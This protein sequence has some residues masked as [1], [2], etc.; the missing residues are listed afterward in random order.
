VASA[1]RSTLAETLEEGLRAGALAS[2][3]TQAL[4]VLVVA[5]GVLAL[6]SLPG[7]ATGDAQGALAEF[8]RFPTLLGG[9]A[10]GSMLVTLLALLGGGIFAK[11]ADVAADV[12]GKIDAALPEDSSENPATVTDLVGDQVGDVAVRGA[13]A[14]A[15]TVLETLAAMMAAALVV[16]DNPSLPSAAA[17][18]LMPL[19]VRAFTLVTSSFGVLVVRTNDSE[20]PASALGRGLFVATLLQVVVAMGAAKWLL[21]AYFWRCGLAAAAGGIA[22]FAFWHV[23][24]YYGQER[25]RPV[26]T[27][28]E[29]ARAGATTVTLRGLLLAAEATLILVL[30]VVVALYSGYWLGQG[31]GLV[32]GGLFGIAL[33]SLGLAGAAPYVQAM[34]TMS[35][36]ADVAAGLLGLTLA[37]ELSD[38]RARGRLFG[39]LGGTI[40]AFAR[41]LSCASS[42]AA[43][44]VCVIVFLA[45][46][47]LATSGDGGVVALS[48]PL[49]QLGG[50][51]GIALVIFFARL[52]LGRVVSAIRDLVFELRHELGLTDESGTLRYQRRA[53]LEPTEL[54]ARRD[55]CVEGVS[56][57]ALRGMLPPAVFGVGVP[58]VLG[59]GLR[60]WM[61]R[62]R[63]PAS[64]EALAAFVL[65]ATF[66]GALGSL[67]FSNAKSAWDNAKRYVE[68]GAH[69]GRFVSNRTVEHDAGQHPAGAERVAALGGGPGREAGESNNPTYVAAVLGDTIG[70]PLD[71]VV[72]PSLQALVA[73]LATLALVFLPFF[74]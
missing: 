9:L 46:A 57:A 59:G 16:R 13:H 48:R 74:L 15:L 20:L 22:S 56:R 28:A 41:T 68:T 47:G 36:I 18:V 69:G 10:L 66:A 19:V 58:L 51:L 8:V 44:G 60:W 5:L 40:K 67:L 24:Q 70:D 65:F 38:V 54:L 49:V 55:G 61:G 3:A 43:V 27:L 30:L 17:V 29:A 35:G 34:Y 73:T 53:R 45:H 62:D 71:G 21:P 11:V 1:M 42:T 7:G 72:G 39:A 6:M 12:V 64:A 37:S 4:G 32:H 2:A 50:I 25:Y 63:V 31:T 33:T 23:A 26:R 14:L 52:V